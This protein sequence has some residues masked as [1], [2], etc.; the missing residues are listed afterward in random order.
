MLI[1]CKD[2]AKTYN[3][4][5]AQTH[6][7]VDADVAIREG[8][9][10][11]IMGP[12]GS[13]KSTLM[14]IL[15]LLDRPTGGTY[16][17]DGQDTAAFDDD[18]LARL[19]NQNFGFIFQSFNLLARV[20]VADNVALP[21][22]YDRR[23]G[24]GDEA[25]RVAAVLAAV[26]MS[27]RATYTPNQLSGGEQQRTA[28]ARALINDPSVIFADEPTGN[29]DSK[30]GLTVMRILQ[31]LHARGKT[32][33]LVTHEQATAEHA[34]RILSMIDGRIVADHPV[35]VRRVAADEQRLM[36]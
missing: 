30:S 28:I 10:V 29:L 2:I 12:S 8:E 6:A 24:R 9:F 34:E 26:G 22:S 14:Q 18:T 19:R 17:F 32:I 31:D 15:G 21:L 36:K 33:I 20:S 5:V 1:Q 7:L 25:A 23:G 11:A 27:H 13:G 3:N 4:G 35:A 16:L